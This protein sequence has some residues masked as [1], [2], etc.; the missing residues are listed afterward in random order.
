MSAAL[1][2]PAGILSI[3]RLLRVLPLS[4]LVS[5]GI[6]AIYV[7]IAVTAPLWTPFEP[8][9]VL[10]GAPLAPPG[11]EH[12]FG[13]DSLGRDIFSRVMHGTR[14]VL[15][16]S[17]SAASMAV[18]MGSTIGLFSAYLRGWFDQLVMRAMDILISIP[19]LIF[20]I[21]ILSALGNT[22]WLVVAAVAFINMPR[23]ARVVR[24]AALS[25]VAEDYVTSAMMRGQSAPGIV[26][27]ELLPNVLG[28]IFVE[29]AVR[30][31]FIIVFIGAL[32]FLGFGAPPPTPEWGVM[33]NEGRGSMTASVWPVIAPAAAMAVLVV[34]L[35]L[36]TDAIASRIGANMSAGP[37]V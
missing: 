21:L 19:T 23:I 1:S 9:A 25:I 8:S 32:G 14:P 29:F 10:V 11:A 30:S 35:N 5:A 4:G 2:A 31:G 12:L 13:T 18:L 27:I 28:T 37:R 24:A 36:F 6:I 3:F 17:L 20:A 7:L 34:S 33:I 26:F 22:L 15:I 16:M